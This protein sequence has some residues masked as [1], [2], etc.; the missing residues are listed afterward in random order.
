MK[1]V[2]EELAEALRRMEQFD[3]RHGESSNECFERIAT[4]FYVETG[5]L[6]PGKDC[7]RNTPE[8]RMTA[9]E[10]WVDAQ[11]ALAREALAR[12]AAK[13]DDRPRLL[14][15]LDALRCFDANHGLDHNCVTKTCGDTRDLRVA[16]AA[17][18]DIET[19]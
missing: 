15:L 2:R 19:P 1:S 17:C 7:R 6:R 10:E 13:P 18:S 5:Y 11:Y 16:F 14:K 9:W 3:K 4:T 8:E 12:H